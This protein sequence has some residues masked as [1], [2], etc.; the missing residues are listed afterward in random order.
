RAHITIGETTAEFTSEGL[1]PW[2]I[3]AAEVAPRYAVRVP[4]F[5]I[6]AALL[7]T[8]CRTVIRVSAR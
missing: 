1:E 2:R 5:R 4:A 3:E 8:R 7:G 6:S